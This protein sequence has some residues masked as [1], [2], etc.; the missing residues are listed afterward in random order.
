MEDPEEIE[1]ERRLA[2]VAMTR[3]K[4]QLMLS[5]SATRKTFNGMSYNF[6]SRFLDEAGVFDADEPEASDEFG[7]GSEVAAG[8]SMSRSALGAGNSD[9]DKGFA[10]ERDTKAGG[11]GN[12]KISSR[13]A[14]SIAFKSAAP[15]TQ[16]ACQIQSQRQNL[17]HTLGGAV[18]SWKSS[19]A[20]SRRR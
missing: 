8:R 2:Y 3:A 18:P 12:T 1:E 7:G 20:A 14:S 15:E 6:P 11:G 9:G 13:P 17:S 4:D 19:V 5:W 16:S 10:N